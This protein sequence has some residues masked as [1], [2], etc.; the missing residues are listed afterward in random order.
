MEVW[1]S[2]CRAKLPIAKPLPSAYSGILERMMPCFTTS[3]GVS[4]V[5]VDA[6]DTLVD[7]LDH[8]A[9]RAPE[10]LR[11]DAEWSGRQR[12]LGDIGQ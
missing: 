5:R 8:R 2:S 10:F 3:S 7:V 11:R 1:Y 6:L 9:C 4:P 12:D